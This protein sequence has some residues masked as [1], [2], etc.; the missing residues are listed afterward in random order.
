MDML[1]DK[2]HRS[3]AI[4]MVIEQFTPGTKTIDR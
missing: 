4:S 2:V 3:M 1:P